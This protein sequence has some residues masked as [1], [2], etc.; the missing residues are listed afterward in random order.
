MTEA[1]PPLPSLL[2]TCKSLVRPNGV[3]LGTDIEAKTREAFPTLLSVIPDNKNTPFVASIDGRLPVSHAET[4]AFVRDF[5]AAL[6]ALGV[7][8]HQRV[9]VILPNGPELAMAIL[10]VSN[11]AGCVPLSATGAI[12]ELE[13]DLAR[14]GPDL[15]IGPYSAGPLP[16]PTTSSSEKQVAPRL[17]AL[18]KSSNVLNGDSPRD[19]TVHGS[20]KA[21]ADKMGIKFVGLVPDPDKSGPF[22]LWFPIGRSTKSAL[23]YEDLPLVPDNSPE[24]TNEIDPFPNGKDV[25]LF[26]RESCCQVKLPGLTVLFFVRM[27]LSFSLHQVLRAT[28]SLFHTRWVIY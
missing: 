27:R 25:S 20:V 4:W 17:T 24:K 13:A 6:H 10:A 5:G 2:Q 19:W 11:W 22:K 1:E 9:A 16:K 15:V 18:A 21:V 26:L 28:K 7:G 14:C 23:V 12:S 3:I 8:R